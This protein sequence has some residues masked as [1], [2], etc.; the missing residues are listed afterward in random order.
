VAAEDLPTDHSSNGH[1]VKHVVDKFVEVAALLGAEHGV[2]LMEE[3]A[4]SIHV[5]SVT[6]SNT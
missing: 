4:G 2:A 6:K 3:A 1:G 5:E